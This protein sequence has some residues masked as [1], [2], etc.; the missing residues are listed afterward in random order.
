M[1]YK[2]M[3]KYNIVVSNPRPGGGGGGSIMSCLYLRNKSVCFCVKKFFFPTDLHIPSHCMNECVRIF[4][5][6]AW[7]STYRI[8][9]YERDSRV[10]F[11]VIYLSLPSTDKLTHLGPD[12][13][14][15]F[16][17]KS[18]DFFLFIRKSIPCIRWRRVWLYVPGEHHFLS[19]VLSKEAPCQ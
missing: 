2:Y 11:L 5:H 15:R 7:S 10:R 4:L 3:P 1:S 19:C 14:Y 12:N 8:W 17:F 18:D 9:R 6:C 16:C 13:I